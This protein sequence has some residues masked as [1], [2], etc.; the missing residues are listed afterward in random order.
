[1]VNS[2]M[3]NQYDCAVLV[4]IS[5]LRKDTAETRQSRLSRLSRIFAEPRDCHEHRA[6]VLI[7]HGR[8][9]HPTPGA[10]KSDRFQSAALGGI[11]RRHGTWAAIGQD[12]LEN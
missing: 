3:G 7:A 11:A 9:D 8:V 6:V 1:M 4:A 10:G 2:T 12:R 5:W